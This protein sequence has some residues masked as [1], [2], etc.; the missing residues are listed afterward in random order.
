M[1]LILFNTVVENY[2]KRSNELNFMML[3]LNN[4]TDKN[5]VNI[6]NYKYHKSILIF[7]SKINNSLYKSTRPLSIKKTKYKFINRN[8]WQKFINKYW[9]ETIFISKPNL[10]SDNYINQLKTK[11]LSIYSNSDYKNFLLEFSKALLSGK[12]QVCMNNNIINPSLFIYNNN[13]HFKYIWKKSF[14]LSSNYLVNKQKIIKTRSLLNNRYLKNN[15]LPIFAITNQYNQ[16]VMFE[17]SEKI[18]LQKNNLSIL[19]NFFNN[20]SSKKIYTGLLFINPEDA[21]EY[22]QY[23][24][25]KYSHSTRSSYIQSFI[26]QLNLYYKLVYSSI[27]NTEFRLIPDLKEV[28]ELIYKY[29]YYKN[30][31]FDKNQKYGN[32]YFQGQPI[33]L[34]KSFIATNKNTKNKVVLD[35]FYN[36]KKNINHNK[37]Q[38]VFLNYKTALLAWNQ[39][40]E[41]NSYYDLPNKPLLHVSNLENFLKK[42]DKNDTNVIFVPSFDTYKFIKNKIKLKQTNNINKI[43]LQNTSYLKNFMTRAFWSLTSRQPINW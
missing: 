24:L 36:I 33:Y 13:T 38:A 20:I 2:C 15:I 37:Y 6:K 43:F 26:G 7:L 3:K 12:V 31:F 10:L 25:S 29:Q 8:L 39:F 35:Y 14:N 32:N 34:I 23:I 30:I 17:S 42:H 22:K 21:S 18:F 1:I 28:S 4:I 11:G 40:K 27:Y 41:E 19:S 9:Q 16:L 5:F